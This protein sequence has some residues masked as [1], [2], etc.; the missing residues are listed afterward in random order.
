MG[1][2]EKREESS[3]ECLRPILSIIR[4]A[5]IGLLAFP[6]S[7]KQVIQ[8]ISY[9]LRRNPMCSVSGSV[10]LSFFRET[11]AQDIQHP[12]NR[13]VRQAVKHNEGNEILSLG[14]S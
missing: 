12:A 13:D 6:R 9:L 11:E 2:H 14:N 10:S 7:S 5:R 3:S 1:T 4:Q 8:D